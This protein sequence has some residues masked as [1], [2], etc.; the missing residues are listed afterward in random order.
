MNSNNTKSGQTSRPNLRYHHRIP[1]DLELHLEVNGEKLPPCR[2]GNLSRSGIMVPCS[3]EIL[4]QI[5]PNQESVAPHM[6]IPVR[7]QFEIPMGDNGSAWVD[8]GCDVV[9]VR[10]VARDCFH[11]GMSFTSFEDEGETLV[12]R[13]INEQLATGA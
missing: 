6:A 4:D 10:R 2:V 7:A 11:V 13:Y 3:Q 12:D 1:V 9:T 8:C 5:A